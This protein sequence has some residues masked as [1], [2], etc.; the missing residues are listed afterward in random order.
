MTMTADTV[1]ARTPEKSLRPPAVGGDRVMLLINVVSV[2]VPLVVAL[3]LGIRTKFPLGEWTAYLPH[4]TGTINTLTSILLVAAGIA[5]YFRKVKLH[6]ALMTAAVALGAVFL[7]CYVTYHLSNP[8]TPYGG[9]GAWRGVYFFTLISHIALSLVVLPLVLRA[10]AF[11]L[12]RRFDRHA[13]IARWA[14]PIW[15]YVSVTG[16]LVYLMIRPYYDH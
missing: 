3:L 16:V 15:L 2:T 10:F 11:A 4:A 9:S 6:A 14:Y 7:V 1:P 12:T 5:I 8:S 13:A